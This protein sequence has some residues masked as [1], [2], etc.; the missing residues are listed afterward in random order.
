[1]IK[2]WV[3][4]LIAHMKKDP[5]LKGFTDEEL[6]MILFKVRA[7]QTGLSIMVA[8]QLLPKEFNM[9]NRIEILDRIAEDVVTA[10]RIRKK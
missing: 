1:M 5:E 4:E 10:T 7:F 2:K 8:N 6:K 3:T 9:E